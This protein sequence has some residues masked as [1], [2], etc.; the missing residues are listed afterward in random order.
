[1][2]RTAKGQWSLVA[3]ITRADPF[4]LRQRPLFFNAPRK[5]GHWC[6]PVKAVTVMESQLTAAL[7]P[8]EA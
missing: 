8:L 1:V 4:K 3:S 5:G 6:W 2:Y 7:G